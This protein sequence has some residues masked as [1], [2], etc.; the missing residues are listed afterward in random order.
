MITDYRLD[1]ADWKPTPH[2]GGKIEPQFV[3]IH[4]TAGGSA[5]GSLRAM[6]RFGLSAHLVLDRDGKATQTVAFNRAAWHAGRS[7]W[8]GVSGLN[9][10]SIGI[11]VCNYGW[12]KPQPDGT[13][14]RPGETPVFTADQVLVA[15]HPNG[16]PKACG[17]ELY[18]EPQL[19]AL[20]AI[21]AALL[22][23]YPGIRDICGHDEIAPG[24]KQDPGPAMPMAR[25]RALLT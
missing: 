25:L 17:W 23:A 15:D 18:P 2:H 8:M 20:E 16:W 12:L 9:K 6:E 11:E 7:E 24:R 4:Y 10:H 21:C 5:A 19:A 13:Y 22:V 14:Q 1:A 3:V